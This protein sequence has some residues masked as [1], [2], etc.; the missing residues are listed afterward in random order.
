MA[1]SPAHRRSPT[2]CDLYLPGHHLH[3]IQ[4]RKC[5]EHKRFVA[6]ALLAVKGL[7]LTVELPEGVR[8]YR[9]HRTSWFK[10]VVRVGGP[11]YVDERYRVLRNAPAGT[12]GTAWCIATPEDE[13]TPCSV[14]SLRVDTPEALADRLEHRGGFLVAGE[15]ITGLEG[16]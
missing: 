10:K 8:T 5:I 12:K 15:A 13:W 3:F 1:S 7:D 4:I 16:R 11:V 9:T 14:A 2:P 6:G